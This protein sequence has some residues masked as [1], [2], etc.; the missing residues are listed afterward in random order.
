MKTK[1]R[2]TL[3]GVGLASLAAGCADDPNVQL[4]RDMRTGEERRNDVG[5]LFGGDLVLFSSEPD[6]DIDAGESG[7][8]V[9]SFL[10]RAA[11]DT[12]AFMPI[13]S[14]DP[15]GGVILTDWY[16]PAETPDERFKLNV[17]VL[18]RQLRADGITV[19]VFRQVRD[20]KGE[21]VDS[22]V[23]PETGRSIENAVLNRARELRVGSS[24][25]G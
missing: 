19:S 8:A 17:L 1:I 7:V 13:A 23:D 15:F 20:D 24:S 11:L 21:W 9:N 3:I 25:A 18:T 16:A 22:A 6:R 4:D 2:R 12:V 14:A 5:Q 10:W